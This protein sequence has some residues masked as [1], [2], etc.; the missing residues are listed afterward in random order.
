[1]TKFDQYGMGRVHAP[2][3]RDR[4]FPMAALLPRGV[5]ELPDFRYY[6][7]GP[8]LN[9]G[10]TGTCVGHAWRQFLASAPLMYKTVEPTP[11]QIY[12]SAVAVDEWD[13]NDY[14]A[15]EPDTDLQWGTSVRAGVKVLRTAGHIASFAW[16]FSAQTLADFHL[17]GGGTV[18]MGTNWYST[19]FEPNSQGRVKIGGSVV[20][21]HAWLSKGYSATRRVFRAPNSWGREFGVN[22]VFEIGFDD[23]DRLIQEDGDACTATEQKLSPV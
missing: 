1:M 12:R 9:Q 5:K 20:G 2:D 7:T 3:E 21:G 23:M 22:G 18:V 16:A 15:T 10:Q 13:A 11:F 8:I 6:P 17:S 19:M 4:R 14:E